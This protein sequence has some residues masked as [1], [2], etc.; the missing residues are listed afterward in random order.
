VDTPFGLILY[1]MATG[2]RAFSG[3]TAPILRDAILNH[4][5]AP[6]HDLNSTQG[7]QQRQALLAVPAGSGAFLFL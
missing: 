2:Q 4:T 1:E 5:P 6:V 7:V 3:E